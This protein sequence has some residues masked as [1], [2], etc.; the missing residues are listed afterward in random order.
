MSKWTFRTL[1]TQKLKIF[2][3]DLDEN[4]IEEISLPR[5]SY[6]FAHMQESKKDIFNKL[7][8][9]RDCKEVSQ[10]SKVESKKS[11]V[12]SEL[13]INRGPMTKAK[14]CI[15]KCNDETAEQ[16]LENIEQ[17][18]VTEYVTNEKHAVSPRVRRKISEGSYPNASVDEK[19]LP[20]LLR[21]TWKGKLRKMRKYLEDKAKHSKVNRQDSQGR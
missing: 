16:Y 20:A 10:K 17:H 6:G 1:L 18:K 14:K 12:N 4:K 3:F 7:I 11:A 13:N 2:G 19:K 21:Y 15:E 8:R 9:Y 5:L